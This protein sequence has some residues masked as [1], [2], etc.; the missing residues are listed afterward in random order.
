MAHDLGMVDG[1]YVFYT[2]DML[3]DQDAI[4]ST[5][6]W[7]STD[8]RNTAARKAFEAVFN[9]SKEYNYAGTGLIL[10]N[11]NILTTFRSIFLMIF[12]V[13]LP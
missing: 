8:G 5:S 4:A 11:I 2:I 9:V 6:I 10:I 13:L 12:E 1:D 7:S 3:P